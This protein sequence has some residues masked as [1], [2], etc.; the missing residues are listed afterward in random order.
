MGRLPKS[1]VKIQR[2]LTYYFRS[3]STLIPGTINIEPIE[4]TRI[5][6]QMILSL[7]VGVKRNRSLRPSVF[8]AFAMLKMR[9]FKVN[10]DIIKQGMTNNESIF[11]F[12]VHGCSPGVFWVMISRIPNNSIKMRAQ[13]RMKM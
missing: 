12:L 9:C 8:D 1:G 10:Q 5:S 13:E 4:S 3:K 2:Q 7:F 11:P 6:Q